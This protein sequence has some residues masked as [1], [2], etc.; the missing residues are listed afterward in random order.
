MT[1][2]TKAFLVINTKRNILGLFMEK[3]K[4]LFAVYAIV[5]LVS[6]RNYQAISQ[7]IIEEDI[8]NAKTVE[9]TLPALE[10][11]QNTSS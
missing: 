9:N 3:G 11:G 8:F 4:N 10:S 7:I 1:F 5:H 2:V 6:R